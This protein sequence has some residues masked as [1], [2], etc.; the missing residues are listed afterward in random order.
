MHRVREAARPARILYISDFDPA[1]LGMPISVA[2]KIEFFQRERGF[3]DLD[4]RLHP[5]VLTGDQVAHYRLPRVPVKDSDKRKAHFEAAHGEGQVELDALE[6]LYPGEL[7]EIVEGAILQYY[8]PTLQERTREM[9]E[10]IEEDL[11]ERREAVIASHQDDLDALQADYDALRADFDKT[12]ERFREAVVR[13]QPEI[14]AYLTRLEEIKARGRDLY[15]AIRDDLDV[16]DLDGDDYAL[17][18]A[19]LP[20]ESDGLLYDSQRGYFEQ[21]EA[22][23]GQRDGVIYVEAA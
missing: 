12:R 18:D 14:D 9:Y 3:D 6:A 21:L 17:P 4:I 15:G 16:V 19:D 22:Y 20:N 23:K 10:E 1:G 13:H 8:D 5:I 7:G 11:S 2:R